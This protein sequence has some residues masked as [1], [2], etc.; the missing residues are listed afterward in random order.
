MS[1]K[2]LVERMISEWVSKSDEFE[3]IEESK[4]CLLNALSTGEK[5]L[6]KNISDKWT[7]IEFDLRH[8]S[9]EDMYKAVFDLEKRGFIE[10]DKKV[11]NYPKVSMRL[12]KT[13]KGSNITESLNESS[14]KLRNHALKAA[15]PFGGAA[16]PSQEKLLNALEKEGFIEVTSYDPLDNSILYVLTA[17]GKAHVKTIKEDLNESD[18]KVMHKTF[19]DA[20]NTAKEKA[21]KAGYTIDDDEWFRKVSS[22]PRKPGTDK[23]NKYS[24]DLMTKKGNPAKKYLQIQVYNTGNA[25]ELNTYIN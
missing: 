2:N 19:T 5:A 6:L 3:S 16:D 15:Q 11:D 17:K 9:D 25:Y 1:V 13:K 24:I 23:T 21:E 14:T 22:G 18:Y 10:Y 12:K 8:G 7:S 20:V 4:L